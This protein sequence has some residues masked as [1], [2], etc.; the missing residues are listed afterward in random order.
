MSTPTESSFA[1]SWASTLAGSNRIRRRFVRCDA[2]TGSRV[3]LR[4]P[5][6]YVESTLSPCTF[7]RYHESACRCG[8]A[9]SNYLASTVAHLQKYI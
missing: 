2:D 6:I 1:L 4:T 5:R 8:L 7:P 9:V 3:H